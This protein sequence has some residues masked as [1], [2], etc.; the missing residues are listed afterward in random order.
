MNSN[1]EHQLKFFL[2]E[3]LMRS[4]NIEPG[5]QTLRKLMQDT[6]VNGYIAFLPDYTPANSLPV[7]TSFLLDPSQKLNPSWIGMDIGCGYNF[8][9][10]DLDLKKVYKKGKIN[11]NRL[12]KMVDAI[13]S[14]LKPRSN[15]SYEKVPLPIDG[16]QI[17]AD[18]YLGTLG[19][20][21][22]FIDIFY[23][24]EIIDQKVFKSFK[25]Q[26]NRVYVLIH[27]G[28]REL[29]FKVHQYFAELFSAHKDFSDF[30]AA[31]LE[32]LQTA[33]EYARANRR[34]IAENIAKVLDCGIKEIFDQDHNAIDSCLYQN[35]RQ[36]RIRKGATLMQHNKPA[37]IP[38]NCSSPAYLV[39]PDVNI[40]DT[41]YTLPHGTGRKYTRAQLFAK[42]AR[43][44][45]LSEQFKNIMLNVSPKKM[46]EEVP[47]GY[48]PISDIIKAIIDYKLATPIAK[49][50]PLAV[51]VD[52]D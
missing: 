15:L 17:S 24:D 14:V 1:T 52:R 23:I 44:K 26:E 13:D 20:G 41:Y 34:K 9:E 4:V 45:K 43:S 51:I 16:I 42:F 36:L 18:R 32:G 3:K 10:L 33:I 30:N 28:S 11:Q 12:Q 40:A 31:Y 46:I 5:L 21:N 25:L 37:L 29:G 7:G 6:K 22:H 38:A 50:I 39:K 8:L 49:L 19:Q 47:T 2:T 27:S 35:T 48:K